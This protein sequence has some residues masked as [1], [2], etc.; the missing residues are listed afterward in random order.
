M[1]RAQR[2]GVAH[3][4]VTV[5]SGVDLT[6]AAGD[7]IAVVGPNGVGK[8]TLLRV[9]AGELAGCPGWTTVGRPAPSTGRPPRW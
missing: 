7:R 5:L 6:V 2:V 4:A 8:T 9:L 1:L 3:G